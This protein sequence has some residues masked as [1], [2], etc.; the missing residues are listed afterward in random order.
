[1][2]RIAFRQWSAAF[3][4][5][6]I[7]AAVF[8]AACGGD[9]RPSD[10]L[11]IARNDGLVELSL[12]TQ[13]ERL[14][15]LSESETLPAEPAVSPD[16]RQIV[17]TLLLLPI[18]R[19]GEATDFGADLYLASSDGADAR[20]LLE[21]EQ[22]NEQFRS[23]A[24]FPDGERLLFGVQRIVG[25]RVESSIE[26]LAVETGERTLLVQDA[27]RPAV[28]PD[29][30]R[31]AFV[32][33]DDELRETLWIANADGSEPVLLAGP[34]DGLGSVISP[35]FSPDGRLIAFAGSDLPDAQTSSGEG[36]RYAV[37]SAAG[38]G[39]RP[40]TLAF[41]G[42]PADVW[43][44][45]TDGSGLR[46]IADLDL[47]LPSLA[48]AGDGEQLFALAGIGIFLLDPVGGGGRKV[49]DGTF[50]GQLDWIAPE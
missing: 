42:L 40:L 49:G 46:K 50:H 15:I 31:I 44:I 8:L 32:R 10:R 14:L 19:P 12:A 16:G 18:V 47:D 2:P 34:D 37:S 22:R 27:I 6:T 28:S 11:L 4:S 30:L 9:G 7:L 41:N 36:A 43:V 33:Q 24:W 20:I 29:G 25:T 26:V 38:G 23:P 1:M 5:G 21:H 39:A 48:W 45:N 35:R 3:L 13:Q 17:Y